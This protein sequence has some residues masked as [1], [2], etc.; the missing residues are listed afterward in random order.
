MVEEGTTE[1]EFVLKTTE[2]TLTLR[3][4]SE[5][6]KRLW[7]RSIFLLKKRIADARK[8]EKKEAKSDH[9][10]TTSS[11]SP[12]KAQRTSKIRVVSSLRLKS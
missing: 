11:A 9:T 3:A 4:D 5:E 12:E 6:Q 1:E 7:V 10:L 8:Q 2:S